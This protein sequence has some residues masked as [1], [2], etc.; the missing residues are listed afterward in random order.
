MSNG[1]FNGFSPVYTGV[2][3]LSSG[4]Q[5]GSQFLIKLSASSF[6][7]QYNWSE[8]YHNEFCSSS[9][10]GTYCH[11]SDSN[12]SYN[13]TT[14][15][16]SITIGVTTEFQYDKTSNI[17][18]FATVKTSAHASDVKAN[19]PA[20][21]VL[22]NEDTGCFSAH[23]SEATEKAISNIDFGKLINALIPP[24]IKSIS[25]SGDLGN[26][27]K[28]D[29]KL[30]DSGLTF[31]NSTGVVIGITG[32]VAYNGAYYP[33][34]P[35]SLPLPPVPSSTEAHHLQAYV[36][37]YEM[38]AL[39]WAFFQAGLL[40]TKATPGTIPDPNALRVKTYVSWVKELK[41]FAGDNMQAEIAPVAAPVCTFQK[42]WQFTQA[43]IDSLKTQVPTTVWNILNNSMVGN[44]YTSLDALAG[45]LKIYKID[46]QYNPAIEKATSAMGM[47]TKQNIQMTLT[48][49]NGDLK[50]PTIVFNVARTDI[51]TNL[52]LGTANK[53]QTMQFVFNEVESTA[54]FVSSTIP[55]FPGSNMTGIWASAGDPQYTLVL[56]SMGKTGVPLPIMTGFQF[57]FNQATL[58][59]QQDYIS[60]IA[61]VQFKAAQLV[62][63]GLLAA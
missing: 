4:T 40:K 12:N 34:A 6:S 46:S 13:Y 32:R 1:R 52:Q 42:V 59:I 39:Q 36:S 54:T 27:I 5:S 43:N 19:I 49:L 22:Q 7:A 51:L 37:D 57:L 60:I 30:G 58:S 16:G 29:W 50:Q 61:K 14:G 48:I 55:N 24:L 38:N 26:G 9:T 56:N 17:W 21:S 28:F 62:A 3:Q 41:P 63:M 15:V 44:E 31:P 33:E 11:T 10:R 2:E 8:S 45:D 18:T 35:V 47:V 25:S 20:G 23:V 53:A